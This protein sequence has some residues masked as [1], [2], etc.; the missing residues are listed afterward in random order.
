[1]KVGHSCPH[2]WPR[3]DPEACGLDAVPSG[4][5]RLGPLALSRPRLRTPRGRGSPCGFW[6]WR[7]EDKGQRDRD[8]QCARNGVSDGAACPVP[9]HATLDLPRTVTI[10]GPSPNPPQ[11]P[12]AAAGHRPWGVTVPVAGGGGVH[13]HVEGA[14]PQVPVQA[15][16][17]I[18]FLFCQL[19]V[20]HLEPKRNVH[21]SRGDTLRSARPAGRCAGRVGDTS[22]DTRRR[23]RP[24]D[25][26]ARG[27]L[28]CWQQEEPLARWGA[29]C[30]SPR[31][32]GYKEQFKGP[33]KKFPTAAETP[34]NV[35]TP[36][37]S[38]GGPVTPL[39]P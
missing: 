12:P 37:S 23:P 29:C 28:G 19:E 9:W 34:Q 26:P 8:P 32:E 3:P 36:P 21:G 25:A 15:Q 17:V 2:G 5:V 27:C 20:E 33:A 14:E 39:W 16:D 35:P 11:V 30:L 13:S 18:H 4:G 38:Q 10:L 24:P 1:M 6:S 31:S 22:H 7:P